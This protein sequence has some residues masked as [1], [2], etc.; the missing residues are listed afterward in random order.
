MLTLSIGMSLPFRLGPYA[1]T[2]RIVHRLLRN[3][4]SAI[5]GAHPDRRHDPCRWSRRFTHK[6]N[7]K[8]ILTVRNQIRNQ[9]G[10]TVVSFV[11][12]LFCGK[13]PQ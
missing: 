11:M 9:K 10:E 1:S 8:G 5:H 4:R 7:E 3:G 13:K 2:C 12:K 6:G